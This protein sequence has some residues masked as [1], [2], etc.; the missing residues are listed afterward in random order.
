MHLS[1]ADWGTVQKRNSDDAACQRND[2]HH[3]VVEA[4]RTVSFASGGFD[5]DRIVAVVSRPAQPTT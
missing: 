1:A 3:K 5:R 4:S 2:T